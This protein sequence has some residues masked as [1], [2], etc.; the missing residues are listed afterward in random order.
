MR[1]LADFEIYQHIAAQQAVIKNQIDE[2]CSL[3]KVEA[4]LPGFKKKALAQRQQKMPNLAFL[5]SVLRCIS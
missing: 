4:L 2:K 1:E 3:A 5:C